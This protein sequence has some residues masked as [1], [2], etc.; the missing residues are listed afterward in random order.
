MAPGVASRAGQMHGRLG[1]QVQR[2]SKHTSTTVLCA[3]LQALPAIGALQQP[4][5]PL[6]M[7]HG[8]AA[9]GQAACY[10]SRVQYHISRPNTPPTSP[11][12]SAWIMDPPAPNPGHHISSCPNTS[13]T[14][15]CRSAWIMEPSA[16]MPRS[17]DDSRRGS[18][19]LRRLRDTPAKGRAVGSWLKSRWQQVQPDAAGR[20]AAQLQSPA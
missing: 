6:G 11:C 1:V 13:P 15:P 17:R 2:S 9:R 10:Q 3:V 4:S 12:R 19:S 5:P 16:A 8:A 20:Y 18:T 7:T 14:S